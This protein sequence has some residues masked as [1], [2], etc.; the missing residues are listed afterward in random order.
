MCGVVAHS[1]QRLHCSGGVAEG[2]GNVDIWM[3]VTLRLSTAFPGAAGNNI[4]STRAVF[5]ATMAA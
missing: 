5:A 3:C 4:S 1:M 2:G